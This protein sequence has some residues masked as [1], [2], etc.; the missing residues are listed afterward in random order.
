MLARSTRRPSPAWAATTI[1]AL[2]LALGAASY[3]VLRPGGTWAF[4]AGLGLA[5]PSVVTGSLPSLLH[6]FAFALLSAAAL[7]FGRVALARCAVAWASIG[8]GFEALQHDRVA[9]ALF[10]HTLTTAPATGGDAFAAL[11]ARYAHGGVFDPADV[12]ATVIGAT[13]AWFVGHR[14]LLRRAPTG[15]ATR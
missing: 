10:P 4:P 11:L 13:L 1:A 3:L 15:E 14:L 5:A 8:I 6:T 7:G 2:A 9:T 12:V